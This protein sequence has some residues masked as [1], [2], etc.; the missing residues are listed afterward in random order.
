MKLSGEYTLRSLRGAVLLLCCFF[1]SCQ[2]ADVPAP[3][4]KANRNTLLM[5]VVGDNSISD[6][7]QK[8]VNNVVRTLDPDYL[9]EN[10]VLIYV[11][12]NTY[13][14]RSNLP[15]LLQVVPGPDGASTTRTV[16]EYPEQNSA[17]GAMLSQMIAIMRRDYPATERYDLMI[18][19]HGD[20]WLPGNP[21]FGSSRAIGQDKNDELGIDLNGHWIEID[22]LAEAIP[23]GLFEYILLDACYMASVEVA[24]ALRNDAKTLIATPTELWADGMP[25][26][27]LGPCFFGASPDPQAFCDAL[28]D[29]YEGLGSTVSL[30]ETAPL[31]DLAALLRGV[32][33]GQESRIYSLDVSKLQ[34]F[35]RSSYRYAFFDLGDFVKALASA[36][37]VQEFESLMKQVVP[38]SRYSEVAFETVRID[39][40]SGLSTYIPQTRYPRI[41]AAYAETE[42]TRAVYR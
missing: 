39:R 16:A 11:D 21:D 10:T 18:S 37:Q 42:W 6:Y 32:V 20:G 17:S 35:G 4:A 7:L 26:A 28:Y 14:Q 34:A 13:Q 38:Y 40:Y 23:D 29:Q 27:A 31:G 19:S 9:E 5:Y 12:A 1:A 15:Q 24:Y 2:K 8:S 30:I 36:A 22:A 41:N 3:A 25:Y 33:S